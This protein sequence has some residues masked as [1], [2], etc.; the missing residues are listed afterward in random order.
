MK[1]VQSELNELAMRRLMREKE[2]STERV[3]AMIDKWAH[4]EE[5]LAASELKSLGEAMKALESSVYQRGFDDQISL[6]P[7][8]TI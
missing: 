8:S 7:S 4:E 6:N 5:S 3:I 1:R 2:R